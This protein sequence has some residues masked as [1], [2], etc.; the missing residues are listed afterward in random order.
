M[1]R[2]ECRDLTN[3]FPSY[4]AKGTNSRLNCKAKLFH[5]RE[6]LLI[7]YQNRK[8]NVWICWRIQVTVSLHM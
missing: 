4:C 8:S 5:K 7:V 6:G 2:R 3:L 1:P